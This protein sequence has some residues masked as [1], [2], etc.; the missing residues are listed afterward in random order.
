M[1]FGII[2]IAVD[3]QI[4]HD[5]DPPVCNSFLAITKCCRYHTEKR[6]NTCRKTKAGL[7]ARPAYLQVQVFRREGVDN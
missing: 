4:L 5:F 3:S 6:K 7:W 1:F 2:K